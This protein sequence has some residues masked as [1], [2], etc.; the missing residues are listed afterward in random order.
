M[1][2]AIAYGS[3]FITCF[4]ALVWG[5]KPERAT[6]LACLAA[7]VLTHLAKTHGD[8]VE[9]Q[10]GILLVDTTLSLCFVAIALIADRFWPIPMS[11]LQ[12][13]TVGGH[14]LRLLSKDLS[15]LI[16]ETMVTA[17][18]YPI[19]ALL[20]WATLRDWQR[21]NAKAPRSLHGYFPP[22]ALPIRAPLPYE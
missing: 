14:F 3:L 8:F 10:S 1:H 13:I 20:G 18:Y 19:M 6:A 15:P 2:F 21:R 12:F 17:P 22:L 11:A 5:G 9:F 7:V 16:Y 4:S